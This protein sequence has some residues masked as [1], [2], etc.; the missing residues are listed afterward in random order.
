MLLEFLAFKCNIVV[1][2]L[3]MTRGGMR[4]IK[5]V[6]PHPP[7]TR[8]IR[9]DEDTK[10]TSSCGRDHRGAPAKRQKW[11]MTRQVCPSELL[12][13][14]PHVSGWTRACLALS[15]RLNIITPCGPDWTRL[16]TL[17]WPPLQPDD[18][19]YSIAPHNFDRKATPMLDFL[20]KFLVSLRVGLRHL[21]ILSAVQALIIGRLCQ[22]E[23]R[24]S[25]EG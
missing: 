10:S 6:R 13:M 23:D 3:G 7:Q 12:P 20:C 15:A 21:D 14:V 1:W 11:E 18:R 16:K 25:G 2:Y 9:H 8:Q 24:G 4:G 19:V 22:E 17:Q 5:A